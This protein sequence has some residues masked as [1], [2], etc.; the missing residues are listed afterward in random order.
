[1]EFDIE[2]RRV[3][4]EGDSSL[5]RNSVSL[6]AMLKT[7]RGMGYGFLVEMSS[8]EETGIEATITVPKAIDE[9]LSRYEVVF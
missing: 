9:L 6:K 8:L 5:C 4:L 1:M 3:M 2:G 7:I